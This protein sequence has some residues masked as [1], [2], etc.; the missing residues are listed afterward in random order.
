MNSAKGTNAVPAR[1]RN[2]YSSNSMVCLVV[3]CK[4]GKRSLLSNSFISCSHSHNGIVEGQ[5]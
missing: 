2:E 3:L 4:V 5:H 1:R